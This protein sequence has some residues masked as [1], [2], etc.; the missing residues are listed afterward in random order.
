MDLS[1]SWPPSPQPAA[2]PQTVLPPSAVGGTAAA[3]RTDTLPPEPGHTALG[4]LSPSLLQDLQRFDPA[5]PQRELLEV[6][7][8][9]IRHTQPLAIDL[10]WGE[11]TLTLRVFPLQRRV[12]CRLP[13]TDILASD[14]GALQVR[15]VRPAGLRPPD[16]A[17]RALIAAALQPGSAAARQT[18]AGD[19]A[20]CAPLAPL[21]WTIA[22]RGARAALLPELAGPA[23]YRVAPDLSLSGL[24][25]PGAMAACIHRL[26]R[27][28]CNLPD[29]AGWPGVGNERATRLLNA[30]YLQSGLIVSRSHPA[31]TVEGWTGYRN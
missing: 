15:Q 20:H 30:L 27:Q 26:R 5:S 16:D 2:M 17:P 14:L 9:A 3:S 25:L 19:A 23:A 8:A 1:D 6:L 21:L 13:L 28:T 7:A 12:Y 4:A 31:A 24:D 18:G 22:M 10:A 11:S 29:I